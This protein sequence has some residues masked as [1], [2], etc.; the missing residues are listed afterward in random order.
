[1]RAIY[2]LG[3]MGLACLP[4][5]A[6]G[7]MAAWRVHLAA[8]DEAL[9]RQDLAA[10]GRAWREAHLA[11]QG[12]WLWTGLVEVAD[13]GVRLAR[14]SG[15]GGTLL[16]QARS[17]YLTAL[18]RARQQRS[19]EGMLHAT[20]GFHRLGDDEATSQALRM[21]ATFAAEHGDAQDRALVRGVAERVSR[22]GTAR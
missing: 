5:A 18:F 20:E 11:A 17:L 8:M 7:G 15:E 22:K 1:M 9:D 3:V 4:V 12:S 16:P 10:A 2:V 21:A 6:S 13:G 19:V 14:A